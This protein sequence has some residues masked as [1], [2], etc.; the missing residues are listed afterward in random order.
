MQVQMVAEGMFLPGQKDGR[1]AKTKHP[2]LVDGSETTE[3]DCVLCLINTAMLPHKG[4][5]AGTLKGNAVKKNGTLTTKARKAILKAMNNDAKLLEVL[6][7]FNI[8]LSLDDVL[9]EQESELLCQTVQK[10]ARG[11]KTSTVLDAALK[12]KLQTILEQ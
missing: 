8:L 12:L 3:L 5:F 9:D 6:C 11:Q 10:W 1:Y 7:D 4:S 2:V